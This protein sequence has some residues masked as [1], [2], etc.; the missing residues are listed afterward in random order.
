MRGWVDSAVVSRWS[1]RHEQP[2]FGSLD[3]AVRRSVLALRCTTKI[4]SRALLRPIG[5]FS[6][7]LGG[8]IER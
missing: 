5:R 3:V 2:V 8:A 4:S 6:D 7:R 1:I